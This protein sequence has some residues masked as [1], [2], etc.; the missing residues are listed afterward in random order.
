VSRRLA[1]GLTCVVV[2]CVGGNLAV[3]AGETPEPKK[4][5][6]QK[7]KELQDQIDQLKKEAKI[8]SPAAKDAPSAE[9]PPNLFAPMSERVEVTGEIRARGEYRSVTDYKSDKGMQG[10]SAFTLLR[11]RLAV[12]A[13]VNDWLRGYVQFQDSR[14]FGE[15]YSTTADNRSNFTNHDTGVD[16]HQ[17]Y[18][19]IKLNGILDDAPLTL[20]VGRQEMQYG[21]GRLVD[22][23]AWGNA[24]RSFDGGRLIWKDDAWEVNLFATTIKEAYYA[25]TALSRTDTDQSFSGLHVTYTGIEEHTLDVYAYYRDIADKSVTGEDKTNNGGLGDRK[26][27]TAGARVLGKLGSWDYEAEGAIQAGRYAADDELAWMVVARLGYT[28]KEIAWKP[29]LGVEYDFASGD[30]DPTDGDH[31]GFDDLYG[32][33]HGVLGIADYTG[34]SNLHDFVAQVSVD[35]V[36]SWTVGV[37]YHRF[38]LA[39]KDDAWRASDLSVMQQDSSGDSGRD[40]GSEIDVQATYKPLKNLDL[41][42]GGARFFAGDYVEKT[43]GRD[44]DA[45][46]LFMSATVKF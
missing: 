40:L 44:K 32:A 24:G 29:R 19:D 36:K 28:I 7:V 23:C 39:E 20:R 16:L 15:E 35:P 38:L 33:R 8:G 46:W 11:T 25:T 14:T 9:K 18:F 3:R 12:D 31:N 5:L 34:R 26:D 27:T 2:F 22:V 21:S 41:S 45:T 17:G 6:E 42:F 1:M 4:T 10:D 13:K 30:S 43:T 37:D